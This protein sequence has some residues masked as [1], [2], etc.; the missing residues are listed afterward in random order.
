MYKNHLKQPSPGAELGVG[1]RALGRGES[2][3][4]GSR[5]LCRPHLEGFRTVYGFNRVR[6]GACNVSDEGNVR[7]MLR[8]LKLYALRHGGIYQLTPQGK[9]GWYVLDQISY[10]PF[11]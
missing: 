8:A 11:I 10:K 1:V 6:D 2:V 4:V 5:P 9:E 3:L 7:G